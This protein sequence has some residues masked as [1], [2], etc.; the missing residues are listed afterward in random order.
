MSFWQGLFRK[1]AVDI[2]RPKKFFD[3]I[4]FQQKVRRKS[5]KSTRKW[6][7]QS[8]VLTIFLII[9]IAL[10]LRYLLPAI[11]A[12]GL[13]RDG[14]Y[15]ILFQNNSEIRSSGGFIGSYTVIEIKNFEAQNLEFNTNIYALDRAFAKENFVE[16]P[17][18]LEKVLKG[19]SWALRDANYAASFPEA[20]RDITRFYGEETGQSIDGIVALNAQVMIELL[21]LTGPIKMAKYDL[22]I[23]ADNFYRE[24]QYQVEKAYFESP[25][26]WVINE[27]KTILKDLY[28]EILNRALEHK[29]SLARLLK[30][31]IDTREIIFYFQEPEKQQVVRERQ[32]A[33]EIPVNILGDYLYINSNSYS[34]NKS[35]LS[36]RENVDYQLTDD[37]SG[38]YRQADLTVSRVHLGSYDW[39]DG[40]NTE[41]VR[42]FTP[43]NTKFQE[44]KLNEKDVSSEIEV[45][46]DSGKNY[47]GVEITTEPGQVNILKIS[48]LLPFEEDY[49]LLV[50]K[51]PGR[52]QDSLSV[53]LKGKMLFDGVLDR[54]IEI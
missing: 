7:G 16:P 4:F 12:A 5:G 38:N 34:G 22:T 47:F 19:Q 43:G 54:D 2:K 26:N 33:G 11:E 51:Q 14:R 13:F 23:S 30:K 44:A 52:T 35:S 45:G 36:I 18:P 29:L 9:F 41:W 25:E 1:K 15:L 46:T 8:F 21:K 24:T 17:A 20:A 48:Y 27:P 37:S 3:G 50:Q 40:K 6:I 32:W 49:H 42:I 53:V 10:G 31:E 39:P 28:P